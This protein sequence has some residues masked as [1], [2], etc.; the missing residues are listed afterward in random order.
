MKK[1]NESSVTVTCSNC[2]CPLGEIWKLEEKTEVKQIRFQCGQCKD[3]SFSASIDCKFYVGS[4]EYCAISD[5]H[6]TEGLINI[7]TVKVKD[8]E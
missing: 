4:T 8:Y 6:E 2:D 7:E 5:I 1:I 3:Y